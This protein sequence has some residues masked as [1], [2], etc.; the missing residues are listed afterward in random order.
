MD[1]DEIWFSGGSTLKE[2]ET[3]ILV[4]TGFFFG[5]PRP[6]RLCGPPS[7]PS[8]GYRGLLTGLGVKL[9]N[10]FHLAPRLRISGATPPLSNVS[11]VWCLVKY[12]KRLHGAVLS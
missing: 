2:R 12:R 11:M 3:Y 4:C 9:T 5:P 6:N 10:Q 7:L 1:F 8:S